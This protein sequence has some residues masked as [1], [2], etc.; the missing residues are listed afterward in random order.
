MKYNTAGQMQWEK[1]LDNSTMPMSIQLNNS[2]DLYVTGINTTDQYIK[3]FKCNSNNGN[4][5]WSIDQNFNGNSTFS[6]SSDLDKNDNF[7]IGTGCIIPNEYYEIGNDY[8]IAFKYILD[9]YD[10]DTSA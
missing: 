8:T 7:Y 5:I 9:K 3:I 6:I 1:T 4:H 2:G 10:A